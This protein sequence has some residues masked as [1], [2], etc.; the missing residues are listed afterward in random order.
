M[1]RMHPDTIRTEDLKQVLQ[2][3]CFASSGCM[4]AAPSK[5]NRARLRLVLV[6]ALKSLKAPLKTETPAV[7]GRPDPVD[8]VARYVEQ[9]GEWQDLIAAITRRGRS[10]QTKQKGRDNDKRIQH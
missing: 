3:L 8:M 2:E 4:K 9:G 5:A 1:A 7:S 6:R 10:G